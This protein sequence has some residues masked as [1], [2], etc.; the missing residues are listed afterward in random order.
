MRKMRHCGS[1]IKAM[2]VRDK[3]DFFQVYWEFI[4]EFQ[5]GII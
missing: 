5:S 2:S 4:E 3:F 1:L